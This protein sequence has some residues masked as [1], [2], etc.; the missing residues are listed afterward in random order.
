MAACK[1]IQYETDSRYAYPGFIDSDVTGDDQNPP[2]IV[3]P[4]A[5]VA[6]P[7]GTDRTGMMIDL[8]QNPPV[9]KPDPNL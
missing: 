9:L 8:S 3:T 6:V 1:W 5:Q 7:P 2:P 4:R